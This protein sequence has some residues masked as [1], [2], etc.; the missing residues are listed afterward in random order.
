MPSSVMLRKEDFYSLFRTGFKISHNVTGLKSLDLPE[1][2]KGAKDCSDALYDCVVDI[3]ALHFI[4]MPGN[5]WLERSI[6]I[7][8]FSIPMVISV[9]GELQA[10]RQPKPK[11]QQQTT[12]S[13]KREKGDPTPDQIATLVGV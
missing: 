9:K 2:D 12:Q 13:H 10:R 1:E 7:G 8:A 3:P 6:A 4:L 5:K 11:T